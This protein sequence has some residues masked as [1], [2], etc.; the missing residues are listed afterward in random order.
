MT[1]KPLLLVGV[2]PYDYEVGEEVKLKVNS[3]NSLK[4]HLAYNFYDLPYCRPLEGI[5]EDRESLG[6]YLTGSR[7]ENS[8]Y[9][10]FMRER[11]V[12]LILTLTA[13]ANS[14]C[15]R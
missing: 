1:A 12:I 13:T 14:N 4:T 6:E 7:I 3:M 8:A 10:I 11:E 2:N 9:E 5:K 15:N